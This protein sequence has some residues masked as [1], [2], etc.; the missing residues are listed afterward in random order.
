MKSISIETGGGRETGRGW[1]EESL[2]YKLSTNWDKFLPIRNDLRLEK[3]GTGMEDVD[4]EQEI[5]SP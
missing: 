2:S 4:Q 1:E 3:A 5:I